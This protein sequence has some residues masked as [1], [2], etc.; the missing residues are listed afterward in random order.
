[1]G[2]CLSIQPEQPSPPLSTSNT[3]QTFD[4]TDSSQIESQLLRVRERIAHRSELRIILGI[5]CTDLYEH[6]QQNMLFDIFY[7]KFNHATTI[8]AINN[9]KLNQ[10]RKIEQD[11]LDLLIKANSQVHLQNWSMFA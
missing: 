3:K 1:M 7:T 5:Q 8:W 6:A 11:L 2:T 10:C 9:Q 4:I